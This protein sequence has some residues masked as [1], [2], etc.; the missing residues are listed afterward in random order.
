MEIKT[1]ILG[2]VCG[3]VITWMFE[4][5]LKTNKKLREKYY[6]HHKIFWGYHIHHSSYSFPVIIAS[7]VLFLQNRMMSSVFV[8][9]IAA[10]IIIMHTISDGRFVFIDKQKKPKK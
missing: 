10:G 6:T 5:V 8:L 7:V 9:G 4:L 2:I 1:L 3:L